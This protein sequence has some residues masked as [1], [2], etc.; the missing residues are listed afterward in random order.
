[1]KKVILSTSLLIE[2]GL[3]TMTNISLEEANIWNDS[4][5][6]N[7]CGHQTVK[8]LGL[9]PSTNREACTSYDEALCFKPKT[10]LVF[11]QEY[12]LKEILKIGVDIYL[13]K[14]IK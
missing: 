3:F 14:K 11:G 6:K 1:M 13:I 12:S 4:T 10:R 9:E 8:L 7:F 2:T 5:V